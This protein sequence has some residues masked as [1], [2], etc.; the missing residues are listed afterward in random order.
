MIMKAFIESQFNYCPL[1]WVF[2]WITLISKV[3]R[4]HEKA[5]RIGFSDYYKSSFC[6]L[7][8]KDKSFSIH[9]ENIPSLAIE[10]YKYLH[11]LSPFIMNNIF[12]VNQTVPY[13]FKKKT[14]SKIESQFSKTWYRDHILHSS[15]N[16]VIFTQNNKKLWSSKIFQTK[17]KKVETWLSM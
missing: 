14:F 13:N 8:E 5:P 6:V 12:K 11:N 4:L 15:E 2:R 7:L 3:I 1:I 16:M 9:H 10:I 17:N